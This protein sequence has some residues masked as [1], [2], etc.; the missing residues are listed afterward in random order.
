MLRELFITRGKYYY[1][2]INSSK[3]GKIGSVRFALGTMW[4][5]VDIQLLKPSISRIPR[6]LNTVDYA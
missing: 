3:S 4:P 5:L 6:A 2:C 1:K